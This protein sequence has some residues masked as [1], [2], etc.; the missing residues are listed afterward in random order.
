MSDQE[1]EIRAM[2]EFT[3]GELKRLLTETAAKESHNITDD[4]RVRIFFGDPSE[5]RPLIPK[6]VGVGG[7][8][9]NEFVLVVD[10]P[11]SSDMI[12]DLISMLNGLRGKEGECNCPECVAER[13]G[14][15]K[16]SRR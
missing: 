6:A 1:P 10:K 5:G 7:K 16:R 13:A 15:E 11:D 2:K 14:G 8:E 4:S 9:E 3:V 12:D